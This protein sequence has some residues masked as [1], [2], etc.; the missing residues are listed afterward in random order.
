M[1]DGESKFDC[2]TYYSEAVFFVVGFFFLEKLGAK[3]WNE[4]WEVWFILDSYILDFSLNDEFTREREQKR[5]I[6]MQLED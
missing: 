2:D 5:Q 4:F 1:E 6:F 3:Q